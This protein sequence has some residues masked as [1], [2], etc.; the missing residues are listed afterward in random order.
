MFID[1]GK[2]RTFAVYFKK[3]LNGIFRPVFLICFFTG[4]YTVIFSRNARRPKAFDR[5]RPARPR[6]E[7]RGTRPL[8]PA[9]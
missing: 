3:L 2:I 6:C 4:I 7:K 8:F 9:I 5:S 1:E